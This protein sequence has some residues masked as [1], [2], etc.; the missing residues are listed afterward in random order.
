MKTIWSI[1]IPTF[2]RPDLLRVAVASC[3]AQ[4]LEP[5]QGLEIIV[6]DNS[7]DGDAAAVC[8]SLDR[9]NLRYVHEPRTGLAFARNRGIEEAIGHYLAFLDDDEEADADWIN[10][11]NRA[12]QESGADIVCGKVVAA[13]ETPS[14]NH[15]KYVSDFYTRNIGRPAFADI[16]DILNYVGTGNSAYRLE[17]CFGGGIRV[18][19]RFNHF[20]GEDIELFRSLKRAGCRFAWAPAALV[21][22]WVS[23]ARTSLP[24]LRER[25]RTQG[26]Q[27]VDGLW[28]MGVAG[29]VRVPLFMAGGAV[30]A[31][32][33]T[34]LCLFHWLIGHHDLAREDAVEIQG[35]LGKVFWIG[36][37]RQRRYGVRLDP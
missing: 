14:I 21:R 15:H 26:Q 34:G 23:D 17:K 13:L 16:G 37:S 18:N 30:Q 6:V 2:H 1:V 9:G 10:Q 35:G 8:S 32:L 36:A 28:R 5:D 20:G 3:Y 11:L 31:T 25:R 24:Y 12:F 27:R 7:S 22:E 33:H 4:I 29:R 19:A